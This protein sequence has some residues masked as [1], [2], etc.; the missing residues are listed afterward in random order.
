MS[1]AK[2][3]AAVQRSKQYTNIL[4]S[5]LKLVSTDRQLANGTL[6]FTGRIKA[7][8]K[9]VTP[10]FKVT[11]NGAVLSNEFVARAV[12]SEFAGTVT[13]YRAQLEAVVEILEKRLAA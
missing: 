2:T 5:G 1:I 8:K 10:S 6:A 12:Q 7:G 11:A 3:L 4:N 13:G 9:T